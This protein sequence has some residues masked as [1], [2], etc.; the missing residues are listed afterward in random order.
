MVE[1]LPEEARRHILTK[2]PSESALREAW[3]REGA[4]GFLTDPV[5]SN[6]DVDRLSLSYSDAL[7]QLFYKLGPDLSRTEVQRVVE[8]LLAAK[9]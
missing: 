1:A 7:D 6:P 5:L 3:A 2:G 4:V 9:E 8:E